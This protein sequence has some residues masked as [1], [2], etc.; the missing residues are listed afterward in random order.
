MDYVTRATTI[1]ETLRPRSK[2]F[3]RIWLALAATLLIIGL[4]LAHVYYRYEVLRLGYN[5]TEQIAIHEKLLE[6]QR[7]LHI[8]IRVLS[9]RERLEPIAKRQYA[10]QVPKA[11]QILVIQQ[12]PK[13]IDIL[14]N[15]D[16]GRRKD[17]LDRIKKI[18]EKD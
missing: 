10:M 16:T 4:L 1:F 13:T 2:R 11:T 17:G 5:L 9:R 6:Q 7:K 15:G 14:Q 3:G 12:A 18:D 8:E